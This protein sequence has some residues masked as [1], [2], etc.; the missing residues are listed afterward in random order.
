[1]S[2]HNQHSVHFRTCHLCEAM[3]GLEIH[4]QGQNVVRIKGDEND[5]YS[6]GHICPKAAALQDIHEDPDRLRQP[7]IR[8]G[9]Q[10]K[11]IGWEEALDLAAEK[12]NDIQQTHG[13]DAFAVY[14]GNPTVHNTG[15]I[16]YLYDFFKSLGTRNRFASHSLDQLPQMV[17]S[18]ELYGHQ[19]MFPVPD[20]HRTDFFLIFGANPLVSNGSIMATPNIRQTFKDIQQ[21]NGQIVVVDPRRTRTAEAADQ[22]L[23]IR[24][25]TDVYLL[26]TMVHLLF[27]EDLL[28]LRDAKDY[29][30]GLG[31][32]QQA[33][34]GFT[35]EVAQA[36]TGVSAATIRQLTIDFARAERAVCYG[37]M[38]VSTQ[39]YGTLCHWLIQCLNIL[40]G[41]LDQPGG[42]M[43]TR[44][45]IDFL[46]LL[47]KEAKANRWCS[48]VRNLPEVAGDF[49]TATLIDEMEQKGEGQVRGLM[50]IAGNPALSAP[51]GHRLEAGLRQLDFMIAIDIY[52][53]ETTRHADL[54]LPPAAGLEVLHYDFVL[55]II[56]LR[57]VANY[58]APV[59]PKADNARYDWQILLGL[60]KRLDR[61]RGS[62][63]DRLRNQVLSWLS[64]KRRIDLGLRLGPFGAWG[65][66]F[67]RKHGLSLKYLKKHP[68]GVDLGPLQ[69]RL[70]GRLFTE[71]QTIRLDVPVFAEAIKIIPPDIPDQQDALL[72][73]GRR[74]LLSNNSW[75]HNSPRLMKQ[76][77]RCRAL[78]HPMDAD[79]RNISDGDVVTVQGAHGAITLAVTL[80]EEVMPGV[81][82]IPHGWG[83][84]G[85]GSKLQVAEQTPGANVNAIT[86]HELTDT[87]S[88]NAVF[89]GVPV[90]VAVAKKQTYKPTKSNYDL[91]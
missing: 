18:G 74:H 60:Q 9:D 47:K 41:Q 26:A 45:A 70:P 32:L 78:M 35:P 48:R 24:P 77:D 65:G 59:L 23:F 79:Q 1:M 28:R 43:F 20:L 86:N 84:D 81:L 8:R 49:P 30:T 88:G 14:T 72:L 15:T 68:H 87:L 12:I 58:S 91:Q 5:V 11:P 52:C 89:N 64:P 55:A 4:V 37:R 17:V 80:S 71:N 82:C 50:T 57:N 39:E 25:G 62:R 75:M 29:V 33:V 36:H 53:N 56:A 54:I 13:R 46:Q 34:A 63:T 3:C 66:R 22:H 73:I 2:T 6:K 42:L 21:R 44:P 61:L 51:A 10:W 76:K 85:H 40:T 7:M 38:G 16:L 90:R 31:G 67:L 27:Q 69:P 83:H 19:A